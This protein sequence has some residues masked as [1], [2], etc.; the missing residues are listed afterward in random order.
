MHGGSGAA[1]GAIKDSHSLCLAGQLRD[2]VTL[3]PA[4]LPQRREEYKKRVRQ[5]AAKYPPPV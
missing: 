3:G 5:E 4:F 2:A 1:P